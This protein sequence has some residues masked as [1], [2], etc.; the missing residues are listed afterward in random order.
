MNN[1]YYT[2]FS[3]DD[4]FGS[5]Y[6]KIIQTYI[7]CKINNLRFAYRPLKYIEHNYTNDKEYNN[8]LENVMN[9]KCS[10]INCN[11]TMNIK[12]LNFMNT[13]MPYFESNIDICCES[14]H[15]KF[16]KKCFWE[17]KDRNYFNND[18]INVAIHIRRENLHDKGKA[19]ERATTPNTYYL[20]IM[21]KIRKKYKDNEKKVLFHIYS[22]GVITKFIDLANSDVKFYLNYDICESFIGMVSA[23]ILVISP[24]SLSYIA[25]LISDGEVYYKKFWHNP[26][27]NWIIG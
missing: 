19:G 8:K 2:N 6:Q 16:I 9:L 22:Q 18:K 15:M 4:G 7:Y 14:E 3:Y 13:I 10:I 11:D 25:A 27:K 1:I 21:N 26:R 20:E 17:N 5:Q 12:T 23:E 24:S